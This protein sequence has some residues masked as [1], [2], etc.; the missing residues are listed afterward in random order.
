MRMME[1]Y[2][3]KFIFMAILRNVRP[4]SVVS[5]DVMIQ[6]TELYGRILGSHTKVSLYTPSTHTC[7]HDPGWL[8]LGFGCHVKILLG[9]VLPK[10]IHN[11]KRGGG[12]QEVYKAAVALKE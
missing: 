1:K 11:F 5:S 7:A 2:G 8:R 4:G 12:L 9:V 6:E 3:D 10:E